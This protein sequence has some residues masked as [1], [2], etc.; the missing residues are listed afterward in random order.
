MS[1]RSSVALR[2][3]GSRETL[4]GPDNSLESIN[5]TELDN[6]ALCY[7]AEVDQHY[8]LNRLATTS[9]S[10]PAVIEPAA[11]PGRWTVATGGVQGAQG[12]QGFQGAR[13]AQGTQGA[14]FQ[15]AQGFQGA[16]GVQG[17]QGTQGAGFQGAQGSQGAQGATGVQGGTGAQGQIGAQGSQGSQGASG[18]QGAQG[19]QGSQGTGTQGSQ[20]SAGPQGPGGGAQGA[21]GGTGVQG[22]QGSQGATGAGFQGAQ[23]G[24][25][26]QGAQGGN[27]AQGAQGATGTQGS[28]GGTG[29][30]GTAG[31]QGSQG[32]QGFQ[33]ATGT[34][35]N[36]GFQGTTGSQGATGAGTQG[37]QG[38]QGSQGGLGAQGATGAGAQGLQGSQGSQGGLG[39]QGAAGTGAQGN[40]GFQG[41]TGAGTTG[42]QGS[43]GNQGAKGAQGTAGSTGSQGATG[44]QGLQGQIGAQGATGAGGAAGAQGNQGF[45]GATGA[46]TQGAQG[47]TGVQGNQGFQG[48]TGAGAQGAQ[49]F[50]G[51]KG[52]QGNQGFQG[53]TGVQGT[54]GAQGNQGFQGATGTQG[55]AGAGGA[56]GTQGSQGASAA[57]INP[58]TQWVYVDSANAGAQTGS[59][60]QPYVSPTA[61]LAAHPTGNITLAI[62]AA[63]YATALSIGGDRDITMIGLCGPLDKTIILGSIAVAF[64]TTAGHTLTLQNV[65]I[66]T[67][68]STSAAKDNLSLI[69]V[70][71]SGTITGSGIAATNTHLYLSS[72]LPGDVTTVGM[73]VNAITQCTQITAENANINGVISNMAATSDEAAQ[74]IFRGCQILATPT[75]GGYAAYDTIFLAGFT[76]PNAGTLNYFDNC[77]VTGDIGSITDVSDKIWMQSCRLCTGLATIDLIGTFG[78]MNLYDCVFGPKNSSG[79]TTLSADMSALGMDSVSEKSFWNPAEGRGK[80]LGDRTGSANIYQALDIGE[81]DAEAIG[82]S[83]AVSANN[84]NTRFVI[85]ATTMSA[86]TDL[87]F[88]LTSARALMFYTVDVWDVNGHTLNLKFGATTLYSVTVGGKFPQR[89]R[90]QVTDDDLA[91]VFVGTENL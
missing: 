1:D 23:G 22:N 29:A 26:A 13:G 79:A 18:T 68:T 39:A 24:T 28:Q 81:E 6:G 74:K 27:G 54:A 63:T 76:L 89:V 73:Q 14:G 38:A 3:M 83:R 43:Q 72:V 84:G 50:Q 61:A 91:V 87:T 88:G 57:A 17:S 44:A 34:Q 41:A 35:G 78:L 5:T 10:P 25:G 48:A 71:A 36:Q 64:A 21:Q 15:G 60:A 65:S 56:Q 67:L 58:L 62:A 70:I 75:I 7:V 12:A 20:G 82:A 31:A 69:D 85:G 11:G 8:S 47:G 66:T 9:P 19:A 33:G 77:T 80:M 30:Q 40:Q 90:L 52:A 53:A 32:A 16:T 37:S 49:G 4:L 2:I 42:A 59:I 46:G 51:A 86:N 45:Q 55:T